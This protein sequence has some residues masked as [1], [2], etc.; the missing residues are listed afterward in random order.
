MVFF[1]H[2]LRK[3]VAKDVGRKK[4]GMSFTVCK[5]FAY[6]YIYQGLRIKGKPW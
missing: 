6:I 2:V 1:V 4:L 5:M 3:R